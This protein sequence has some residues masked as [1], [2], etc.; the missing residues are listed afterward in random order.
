MHSVEWPT[1]D[2]LAERISRVWVNHGLF[3]KN[4][5]LGAI[6]PMFF[7]T[8]LCNIL[9]PG[10]PHP[11]QNIPEREQKLS[12]NISELFLTY[13]SLAAPLHPRRHTSHQTQIS[14]WRQPEPTTG[15]WPGLFLTAASARNCSP[16][17]MLNSRPQVSV[18]EASTR[19]RARAVRKLLALTF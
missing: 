5:A 12:W 13:A 4:K 19:G 14:F 8:L 11:L 10:N 7:L 15:S 9:L 3:G 1:G 2:N 6:L 16:S 17:S 18:E